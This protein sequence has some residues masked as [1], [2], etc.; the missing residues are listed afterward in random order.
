MS[1]DIRPLRSPGVHVPAPVPVWRRVWR[2]P[3]RVQWLHTQ[4]ACQLEP[5][6]PATIAPPLVL[7]AIR[8]ACHAYAVSSRWPTLNTM[9]QSFYRFDVIVI[10]G[11]HAGTEAALASAR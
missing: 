7:F 6:D 8:D 9:T 2:L 5:G 11:G 1:P 10:G 3:R 4:G